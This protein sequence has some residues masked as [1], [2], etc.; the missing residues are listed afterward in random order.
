MVRLAGLEPAAHSLEGCCSIRL[1]YRRMV[2]LVAHDHAE[3]VPDRM[4]GVMNHRER[5]KEQKIKREG[6][7]Q[8]EKNN[9]QHTK[10]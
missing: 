3:R 7:P 8:R 2:P 5:S 4:H 10:P 1:S 6:D 9:P